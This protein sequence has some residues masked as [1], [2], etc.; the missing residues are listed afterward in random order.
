MPEQP[1]YEKLKLKV[2]KLSKIEA[3]YEQVLTSLKESEEKYGNLFQSS[4]DAIFIHDLDGNI[5]DSNLKV[6]EFFG[7]T[8]SEMSSIRVP[9]L[10]PAG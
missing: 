4:N 8:K 3:E 10:H 2:K 9:M 1:T 6:L 5:I 7:Y